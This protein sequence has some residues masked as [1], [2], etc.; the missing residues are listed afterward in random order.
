M[1][2]FAAVSGSLLLDEEYMLLDPDIQ[3]IWLVLIISNLG[4]RCGIFKGGMVVI[5]KESGRQIQQVKEAFDEFIR[6]GWLIEEDGYYWI[7]SRIK[8]RG[9]NGKWRTGALNDARAMTTVTP[10]AQRCLDY[11]RDYYNA[12]GTR[13]ERGSNADRTRIE[14]GSNADRTRIERCPEAKQ[15]KAKQSTSKRER[16]GHLDDDPLLAL[17][18]QQLAMVDLAERLRS[19]IVETCAADGSKPEANDL[20]KCARVLEQITRIDQIPVADLEPTLC[21]ALH[22][23]FWSVVIRSIPN[24]RSTRPGK[25]PKIVNCW[26]QW[27]RATAGNTGQ[28]PVSSSYADYDSALEV[29]DNAV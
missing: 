1:A 18:E 10:L 6:L 5:S 2:E 9:H 25:P 23:S 28:A 24:W 22:D 17:N 21:W 20:V 12:V 29:F 8:H 15:S 4:N 27:R 7:R 14:R 11:Y 16:S 13:I 26:L 19:M 3:H